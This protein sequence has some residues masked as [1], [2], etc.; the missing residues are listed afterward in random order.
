[1]HHDL[2]DSDPRQTFLELLR[3]LPGF[4]NVVSEID[5]DPVERALEVK[6]PSA[7]RMISNSIGAATLGQ[8][9]Q[10]KSPVSRN[11]YFLLSF[12]SLQ[13]FARLTEGSRPFPLYPESS[14]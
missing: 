6:M 9:L 1:M 4:Q 14:G 12:D 5:W 10:W 11:P 7:Y 8:G 3:K 2:F 13:E